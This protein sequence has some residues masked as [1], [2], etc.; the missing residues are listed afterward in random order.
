[1]TWRALH[2][3]QPIERAP[4][5]VTAFAGNPENLPRWAAGLSNGIRFEEG[6][7]VTDSPMGTVEV[8]FTGPVRHGVLDH[9]VTLPDGTVVHNPLRVLRNN[10]GSEVVFTLYR[11]PGVTDD[12]FDRD[13]A[14]IRADLGR[15]RSILES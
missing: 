2:L 7:W 15:L 14:L 13:T 1:M 6:R 9:D 10:E 3:S 8:A 11:L 4:E 5:A 12:D